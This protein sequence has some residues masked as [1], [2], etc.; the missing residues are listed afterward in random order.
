MNSKIITTR[1]NTVGEEIES[2]KSVLFDNDKGIYSNFVLYERKYHLEKEITQ[3][4]KIKND[5]ISQNTKLPKP[6]GYCD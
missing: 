6:Q 1:I 4:I 5:K 2:I 3:L